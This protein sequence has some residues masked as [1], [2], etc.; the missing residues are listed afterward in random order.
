[1]QIGDIITKDI[2]GTEKQV[3]CRIYIAANSKNELTNVLK[4]LQNNLKV[5]STDNQNMV[6]NGF[7]VDKSIT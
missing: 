2:I 5:I 6:L 4:L 7:N 1:L 3:Y